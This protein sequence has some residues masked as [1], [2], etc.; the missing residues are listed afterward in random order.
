MASAHAQAAALQEFFTTLSEDRHSTYSYSKFLSDWV[1]EWLRL[2]I[3]L[4][5]CLLLLSCA[6]SVCFDISSLWYHIV[7]WRRGE[8]FPPKPTS[9]C[10]FSDSVTFKLLGSEVVYSQSVVFHHQ[11]LSHLMCV[12]H[13]LV[14]TLM[15]I[16]SNRPLIARTLK[17]LHI[18]W[19]LEWSADSIHTHWCDS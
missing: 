17:H 2:F 7:I 4:G 12:L 9:W 8:F 14:T 1:S 5:M 11:I 18:A 6:C 15:L 16:F 3:L 10:W 19:Y 13:H